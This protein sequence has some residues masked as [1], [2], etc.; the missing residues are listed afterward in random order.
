M[1][2][3]NLFPAFKRNTTLLLIPS[4]L[5]EKCSD[6]FLYNM[7][8]TSDQYTAITMYI[9][10]NLTGRPKWYKILCTPGSCIA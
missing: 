7:V 8:N 9:M 2:I 4:L 3:S 6:V 5:H 10:L 1:S